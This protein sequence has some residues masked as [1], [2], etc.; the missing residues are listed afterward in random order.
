MEKAF[1]LCF[2]VIFSFQGT[3]LKALSHGSLIPPHQHE[4]DKLKTT[5][6]LCYKINLGEVI[7]SLWLM[8]R[9]KWY[10]SSVFILYSWSTKDIIR[11][12]NYH[13][14]L[15]KP[16]ALLCATFHVSAHLCSVFSGPAMLLHLYLSPFPTPPPW[17]CWG[18]IFILY[19]KSLPRSDCLNH[20]GRKPPAE[21]N[22][23][24]LRKKKELHIFVL[25][26]NPFDKLGMWDTF[27]LYI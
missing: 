21:N 7:I 16:F 9:D 1:L 27:V 20:E 26:P 19:F 14:S 13:C 2:L 23:K 6:L 4:V 8:V 24:R 5:E 22:K 15:Q 10:H 25:K 18:G 17:R 11:H 12:K 3:Y